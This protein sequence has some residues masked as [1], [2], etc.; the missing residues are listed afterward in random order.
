MAVKEKM[1]LYILQSGPK[2]GSIVSEIDFL[3]IK[4]VLHLAKHCSFCLYATNSPSSNTKTINHSRVRVSSNDTV[5][6]KDP[7]V[8][9]DDPGQVLKIDLKRSNG[10]LR[11][12]IKKANSTRTRAISK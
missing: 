9:E 12:R 4:N 8:V 10:G 6:V 7:T 1:Y 2:Q 3:N 11:V 5:R